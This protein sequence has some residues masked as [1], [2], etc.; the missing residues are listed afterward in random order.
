M[1]RRQKS[2]AFLLAAL[3]VSGMVPGV[4]AME[5]YAVTTNK[6]LKGDDRYKTAIEVSKSAFINGSTKEAVLISG[7]AIS[8]ALSATPFAYS[9]NAPILLTEKNSLNLN[10]KAEL[11]RLGVN[12]VYV[13][14]GTNSVS[15][16]VINQL[17]SN[18]IT[19]ERI[20]GNDR[21][22]TSLKVAKKMD[23]SSDVS[24]IA[25]VNGNNG[26]PDAISVGAP[27]ARE[28]MPILLTNGKSIPTDID[29]WIKSETISKS[30]VIGGPNTVTD[31][32]LN[33]LPNKERVSGDSRN[34]TNAKV[35]EKFY[36]A[37]DLKTVYVAND[38][39]TSKNGDKL[40][41]ALAVGPVAAKNNAS[42]AIVGN[43]LSAKQRELFFNKKFDTLIQVGGNVNANAAKEL[44][45]TQKSTIE[46]KTV[47]EL[48]NAIARA[49]NNE[50][51]NFKPSATVSESFTLTSSKAVTVNLY[52]TYTGT[53][54]VDM[55]NGSVGN[56]GTMNKVV[57][58]KID[59]SSFMNNGT[60]TNM[61]VRDTNGSKVVNNSSATIAT[62]KVDKDAK[63]VSIENSGKISTVE[64]LGSSCRVNN[65]GTIVNYEATPGTVF[66]G[67]NP[68][69]QIDQIAISKIEPISNK[70]VVVTFMTNVTKA[71]FS[72]F[73]MD[74]GMNVVKAE[75][76]PNNKKEVKLTFDKALTSQ[77]T[78]KLTVNGI[79]CGTNK[80]TTPIS[81]SFV[82]EVAPITSVALSRTKFY[83]TEYIKDALVI[84]D[85][86]GRDVTE[87]VLA[88]GGAEVVIS[89]TNTKLLN[90]ATGI[91]N[92]TSPNKQTVMIN[93]N[94]VEGGSV[95]A[96]TGTLTLEIS[97]LN[98][99][100]IDGFNIGVN[101][102]T[103]AQYK[104]AK[105]DKTVNTL[106]KQ[107]D[108]AKK[109]SVFGVDNLGNIV[110]LN[111]TN[112]TITTPSDSSATI[113]VDNNSTTD[114]TSDDT[115]KLT[116]V[117]TKIGNTTFT[118]KSGDVS[119]TFTVNVGAAST[120]SSIAPE[121]TSITLNTLG[122]VNDSDNTKS[123]K[124]NVDLKDQH[125]KTDVFTY[126]LITAE[127]A[128]KGKITVK[129]GSEVLGKL[130]VA[131][132]D[133]KKATAKL[134][135][136]TK[137]PQ[138]TITRAAEAKKGNSTTVNLTFTPASGRNITS[139]ISVG[140]QDYGN[141][142]GYKVVTNREASINADSVSGDNSVGFS[143]YE[144]DSNGN[145]LNPSLP[146]AADNVTLEIENKS[147]LPKPVQDYIVTSDTNDTIAFAANAQ[148]AFSG[149]GSVN[150]IVKVNNVAVGKV[151]VDYTNSDVVA[152]SVDISTDDILINLGDM[153]LGVDEKL[154]VEE[155]FFGRYKTN[156]Y[157]LQPLV[158]IKDQNGKE[159]K[160]NTEIAGTIT[161]AAGRTVLETVKNNLNNGVKV[162][163]P[164]WAVSAVS[165][166]DADSL[167]DNHEIVF[168]DKEVVGKFTLSILDVDTLYNKDLLSSP[169]YIN[170][171]VVKN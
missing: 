162:E 118:L 34:D 140:F 13:V 16:N 95:L 55:D 106:I 53:V 68:T 161:G 169:T 75:I 125:G 105:E 28:K 150:V 54:T 64:I 2:I 126:E 153:E 97:P 167:K 143:V 116:P 71:T 66:E 38:S 134:S 19:V 37:E 145:I 144:V 33:K 22:E 78:Y 149:T 112:S 72:N 85:A 58:D 98:L 18:N 41:D 76:N 128:D 113:T 122:E 171:T 119:K 111:P 152:S 94:V 156:K 127:G 17:K 139:S 138:V 101:D 90:P 142:N 27:A 39:M 93:I 123:M 133:A 63:S 89:S 104:K 36:T 170:V 49:N 129:R 43:S 61:E 7:S 73:T 48:K 24:K 160:Y 168:K 46:V 8:D 69:G 158:K 62:L 6:T 99:T 165:G 81:S 10:T 103:V 51:I 42:V 21:Y 5:P 30:Y 26:L 52:G 74:G 164:T 40:I 151:K 77:K 50:V 107:D 1:K 157:L 131:S 136:A 87:Q 59:S 44:Q 11:K 121:K 148:Y 3:M 9:K 146:V 163:K 137:Q 132:S 117:S 130:S 109:I 20:S 79:E 110:K 29:A 45:D 82:F 23:A 25:V 32:V 159:I 47:T 67:N 83:D 155:I 92:S 141:V 91:V 147:S 100:N 4:S 115:F 80:L 135:V 114:D 56:Y 65:K 120:V 57:I 35:I 84:K 166:L 124:F 60:I 14:G 70:Q 108:A 12:K 102:M 31:A 86:K 88:A 154:R 96:T 15:D